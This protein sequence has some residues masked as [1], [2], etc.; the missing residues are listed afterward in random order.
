[1]GKTVGYLRLFLVFCLRCFFCLRPVTLLPPD[2]PSPYNSSCN[3]LALSCAGSVLLYW[4][5]VNLRKADD[6]QEGT[7]DLEKGLRGSL[8]LGDNLAACL[9]VGV[10][11]SFFIGSFTLL[12]L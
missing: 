3:S 11:H 6:H 9:S 1:M 8:L 10:C 5:R 7:L 4:G 12:L 2:V